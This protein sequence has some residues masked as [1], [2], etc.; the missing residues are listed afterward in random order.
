MKSIKPIGFNSSIKISLMIIFIT[1]ISYVCST[2]ATSSQLKLTGAHIYNNKGNILTNQ[3][4]SLSMNGGAALII[5]GIGLSQLSSYNN[6]FCYFHA[7]SQSGSDGFNNVNF[8]KNICDLNDTNCFYKEALLSYYNNDYQ[9][10]CESPPVSSDQ[11]E[12]IYYLSLINFDSKDYVINCADCFVKYSNF[13]TLNLVNI[14]PKS[15]IASSD[16]LITIKPNSKTVDGVKIFTP[17]KEEL[18]YIMV[19]NI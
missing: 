6:I 5:E 17:I 7:I 3:Q 4:I 16:I 18:E 12:E 2:T 1:T 15:I 9:I 13:M 10:L 14:T 19:R 11:E 8:N